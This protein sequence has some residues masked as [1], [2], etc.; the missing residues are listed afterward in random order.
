MVYGNLQANKTQNSSIV[1]VSNPET[2]DLLETIATPLLKAADIKKEAVQFHVMLNPVLNAMALPGGHIILNS[3]LILALEDQDEMASVM[4]HEIAHLTSGH[5]TQLKSK[6][7]NLSL[8]TLATVIAGLTAG[9]LTGNGQL[10]Q[11]AIIGGSASSQSS[12][13]DTIRE[14]EKQADQLAIHY[15]TKAGFDPLGMARFLERLNREQ[16]LNN[17]PPPYLLSH[18]VSSQRLME[19]RQIESKPKTHAIPIDKLPLDRV[20]VLLESGTTDDPNGTISR[21][22]KLLLQ[23]PDHFPARYGLAISQRYTGQLL[24]S[25]QN[26]EQ[27]LAKHPK[28]PYLLRERGLTRLELG[29]TQKAEED[30]REA[31]HYK[32]NNTDLLYRLALSLKEQNRLIDATHILRKLTLEHPLIPEYFYLLGVVEGQQ[33]HLGAG[34]LSLARHFR[35]NLDHKMARW[36]YKEAINHFSATSPGKT[37]AQEEMK[38]LEKTNH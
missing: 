10:A 26:F 22:K 23:N 29:Y 38:K 36:H 14:K 32:P 7:K 3:G 21:F 27:I 30:F 11:A 28:D 35:L 20:K 2:G 33:G 24:K 25:E 4:A 9:A 34:H 37:I 15:L 13:L 12:L 6:L 5:H 18:P 16:R 31:L 17:L 8:R 1:L 19:A